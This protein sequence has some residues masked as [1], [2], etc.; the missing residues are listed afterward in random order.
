MTITPVVPQLHDYY[1]ET[2]QGILIDYTASPVTVDVKVGTGAAVRVWDNISGFQNSWTGNYI[3]DGTY[4]RL[5]CDPP[6]AFTFG[7]TIEVTTTTATETL[8]YD[9]KVGLE[10]LTTEADVGRPQ[11]IEAGA[12]V[13][14]ARVHKNE[15]SW[16]SGFEGKGNIYLQVL[17]PRGSEVYTEQTLGGY[18]YQVCEF[19]DFRLWDLTGLQP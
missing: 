19:D 6:A 14:A 1:I 11:I 7:D 13:W 9:F 2:S 12:Y 17:D 3:N 4:I 5:V 15:S 10:R 8:T 16:P 18:A